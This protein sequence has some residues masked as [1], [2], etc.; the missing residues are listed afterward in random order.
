MTKAA[1]K[2]MRENPVYKK[3]N[4]WTEEEENAKACDEE[5]K[6]IDRAEREGKE[7]ATKGPSIAGNGA[8]EEDAIQIWDT[9]DEE[10][11]GQGEY[12]EE[13]TMNK[14]SRKGSNNKKK[15]EE[16]EGGNST[17]EE[18]EVEMTDYSSSHLTV[19]N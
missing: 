13:G 7:K 3:D 11:L 12:Y 17:E 19:I 16:S 15:E 5:G 9:E 4:R 1:E 18:I 14:V 6:E 8:T 10:Y 2:D